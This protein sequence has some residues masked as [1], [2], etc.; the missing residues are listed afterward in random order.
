MIRKEPVMRRNLFGGFAAISLSILLLS[1]C[2]KDQVKPD[3]AIATPPAQTTPTAE[4]LAA[5]RLAAEKQKAAQQIAAQEAAA[6]QAADRQA[7]LNAEQLKDQQAKADEAAGLMRPSQA[8]TGASGTSMQTSEA[9]AKQGLTRINF[10]FDSY[11]LSQASRDTLYSNAEYLLKKYKGKIV[12]EGHCDERGSDEYN[13]ALGENRAKAAMN[14]LLTLGVPADQ[15]S[16][17]SYGKE[18]PLDPGHDEAAWAKNRRV[19]FTPA[20]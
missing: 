19:E 5:E 4:Q 20:K 11:A 12:L 2:A 16:V 9:A 8:T 13:I 1:G 14:Y 10:A 7:A 17:V 18:R 15:L 3:E 6:K